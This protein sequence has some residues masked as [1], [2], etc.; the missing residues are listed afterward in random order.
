MERDKFFIDLC[1]FMYEADDFIIEIWRLPDTVWHDGVTP[2][3]CFLEINNDVNCG[4]L[5]LGFK[6]KTED[7]TY[8]YVLANVTTKEF[9]EIGAGLIPLPKG[10]SFDGA[11]LMPRLKMQ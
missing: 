4:I 9:E 5:P 10:W 8:H 2:C 3:G 11:K 6:G 1:Q 7:K